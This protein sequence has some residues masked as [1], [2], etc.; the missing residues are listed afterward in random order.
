MEKAATPYTLRGR[1]G[2]IIIFSLVKKEFCNALVIA[3]APEK[4][5]QFGNARL[6]RR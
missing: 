3:A 5:A 1:V 6:I 2:I 4:V